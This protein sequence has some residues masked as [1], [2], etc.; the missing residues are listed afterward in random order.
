MTAK[1]P[2][3]TYACINYGNANVP[4]EIK[5]RSILFDNDID[6]VLIELLH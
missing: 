1:N 6:E 3:V 4:D 5:D 2:D